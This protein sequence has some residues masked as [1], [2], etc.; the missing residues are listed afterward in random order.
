MRT[1]S[2]TEMVLDVANPPPQTPVV[3]LW[4][5][6]GLDYGGGD[7]SE[8]MGG[9][10]PGSPVVGALYHREHFINED[11]K[12]KSHPN[13]K[14]Y[15]KKNA[16]V[17]TLIQFSSAKLEKDPNNVRALFIR[18]SSF[19]KKQSYE[20]AVAD[21][22]RIVNLGEPNVGALFARGVAYEKLK[23]F[24]ESV[25][26]FTEVLNID[27]HHYRA[28]YARAAVK[29]RMGKFEDAV[30]D[31]AV[32]LEQD[33]AVFNDVKVVGTNS[34]QKSRRRFKSIEQREKDIE[35]RLVGA[36]VQALAGLIDGMSDVNINDRGDEGLEEPWTP[37]PKVPAEESQNYVVS[38]SGNAM[39]GGEEWPDDL[40]FSASR[41][42][43][44][45]IDNP[46]FS[47]PSSSPLKNVAHPD[48]VMRRT[49][50]ANGSP[51]R[52]SSERSPADYYHA[53]GFCQA[54]A[55]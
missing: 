27:P 18:A 12:A 6:D 14:Y 28:V 24:E 8:N 21:Y 38:P 36:P 44:R 50:D 11:E 47:P 55:G 45:V 4:L 17:E 26:D 2:S 54:K 29:N 41:R 31:Y 34:I 35:D 15:Y 32:A 49:E 3:Q 40:P 51:G 52:S 13:R 20:Q 1:I 16:D 46:S 37:R 43:Q 30:E 7:Y 33:A 25:R 22:T 5:D 10:A 53:K 23:M 19:E 42:Q 48:E 39:G 9:R